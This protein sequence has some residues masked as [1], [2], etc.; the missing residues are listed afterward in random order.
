MFIGLVS[1]SYI[2]D[3]HRSNSVARRLR[4]AGLDVYV[5]D[6]GTPGPADAHNALEAY[7]HRYLPR[8]LRAALAESGAERVSL[9][10]YCMGGNLA[11]LALASQRLP[12]R[13]L[14]TMATPVDFKRLPGL[15]GEMREHVLDADRLAD[16]SGNV[17]PQCLSAFFR[18]RKP[19]AD[20]PNVARLWENLWNDAYVE[21]HQAMARW[22]REHVPFPGAAFR[23]VADQ[24]LRQNAFVEGGLRL[25][26]REVDLRRVRCPTFSILALRDDLVPPEAAQPIGDIIGAHEFE[27]LELEAGHAG[28][29]TSRKAATTTMPAL[30]AWFTGHN[31]KE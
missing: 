15:A 5:L 6:W 14:V 29:T 10:G 9:L 13:S 18:V 2:L 11:L 26:G 24:W 27:L 21:S 20:I 1:R 30:E 23:Q 3:L 16:W 12:V 22:A 8:G 17:P 28:L 19:T 31:E 25:A 4:D 7:T